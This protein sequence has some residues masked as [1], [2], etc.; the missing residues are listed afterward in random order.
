MKRRRLR[1]SRQRMDLLFQVLAEALT[2]LS[3]TD[4]LRSYE[5][6]K[7][8]ARSSKLSPRP[9]RFDRAPA[10]ASPLG[11]APVLAN[12]DGFAGLE[13]PQIRRG[14]ARASACRRAKGARRAVPSHPARAYAGA[15]AARRPPPLRGHAE[16]AD[17][18]LHGGFG[19]ARRDARSGGVSA[20]QGCVH[21]LLQ[22]VYAFC[23]VS[24]LSAL[25]QPRSP[26]P[27]V[28]PKLRPC[29]ARAFSRR[30]PARSL[31]RDWLCALRALPPPLVTVAST[32]SCGT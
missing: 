6:F 12:F 32:P 31:S 14:R 17:L 26:I 25:F 22:C 10:L 9:A 18:A 7:G 13:R 29:R 20:A 15:R 21:I 3:H 23:E 1:C 11:L 24:K 28:R 30:L 27:Q 8:A 4:S 5:T 19:R 16:F 2:L